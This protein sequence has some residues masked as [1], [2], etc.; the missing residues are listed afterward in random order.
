M[1]LELK[2]KIDSKNAKQVE[3]ELFSSLEGNEEED[4]VLDAGK[5][6]YISSAGL[7]IILSLKKKCSKLKIINVNSEIYEILE[8]TGFTEMM[9]VEKACRMVSIE[10]CEV[11]GEGFN[12][13]IYRLDNE[14]IVKVYKNH[15]ALDEIQHERELARF[16]LVMGVPTAI[17]F[18]VVKVGE[19]Y[20]SRFE[21][22]DTKT[23]AKILVEDPA[24]MDWCVDHIIP[25]AKKIHSIN[26]PSG[27]LPSIKANALM[28]AKR[29]KQVLSKE[30]GDKLEQMIKDMPDANHMVHGDLHAKNIVYSGGEVLVID[31]D[32]LSHGDPIF[33]L[34]NMFK[35]YVAQQEYRPVDVLEYP[36]FTP[37]MGKDLWDK[38]LHKYLGTDN[39]DTIV[40]TE[41]IIRCLAY[42]DLIDWKLRRMD[43][44]SED[45]KGMLA[46]WTR[47]LSKLL[48]H[49][50]TLIIDWDRII[51]KNVGELEIEATTD[52]LPQVAEFVET[53]LEAL[54]CP[55]RI[56]MKIGV[57]VEE[58]FV[59]IANYAYGDQTGN[60]IVKVGLEN[61][62]IATVTFIDHGV[63]YDP[64]A[65]TD[66]NIKAPIDE[67][68][69]GG[70]GIYLSKK[71]MDE[72]KYTYKDGN[73]ILTLKKKL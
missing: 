13:T 72:I 29:T 40:H 26:V 39:Q 21:L 45:D 63:P 14:N 3:Q 19:Y 2:G 36:G 7:R 54:G 4:L 22:L 37:Q 68:P 48:E 32:K 12:G 43:P 28:E 17:P 31:M 56:Q 20:G 71:L 35:S 27:K 53:Q 58:I 44:D 50:D 61:N 1:T 25:L 23:F 16:A 41:K 42:S 51:N 73:N 60:A 55:I 62:T 30:L 9:D 6:E 69:I 15:D 49:V 47:E 64:T 66:P 65:K 38:I 18:D 34:S 8:M 33:E 70:L 59:N 24:K 11:I 57:A 5:L 46:F 52:N 10:G 67:R